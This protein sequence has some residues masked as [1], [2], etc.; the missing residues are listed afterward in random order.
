MNSTHSTE[1]TLVKML[2]SDRAAMVECCA[3]LLR[4]PSVNGVHPEITIAEAIADEARSLGLH[5][6]IVGADA[7]RPNVIVSTRAEGPTGLLLL[8]HLDTVP[9]GDESRWRF[10]P[11]AGV[12][13]DGRIYG[14]GAIDT[15]GGMTAALYALAA[16]ARIDGALPNGRAQ[17][18]CV[19]DEE[20]GATGTLGVKYLHDQGLLGGLG[21]I[22]A[23]SGA[24]IT[25]GHR[26]VLRY[27]LTCIG[28]A[29]H[30]GAHEWQEGTAGASAVTGMARLLVALDA[31]QI[32]FS[33][34]K[35]FERFRT[36]ITAGTVIS[37]GTAINIV[38][39]HCEA[40][41]DIRTTPEYDHAAIERLIQSAIDNASAD[42]RL[43]LTFTKL[44]EIPAVISDET[45]PI[46]TI[47][48][49]VIPQI[50][51]HSAERVVAGPANE[52]YLL[53]ERGIPTVCGLG[54]TGANAHAAD[55]YVEIDGLVQAAQIFA[56]TGA[57]LAAYTS[58]QVG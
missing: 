1:E 12:I 51:G 6:Q 35:Y 8:G 20:S 29:I 31:I 19:P 36:V 41:L 50:T 52:G 10:P 39:D 24:Q 22:Y 21:A 25:L 9:A 26:G 15:K 33:S 7:Q 4:I 27:R 58:L 17:L 43:R 30:T 38:P 44:N 48:D 49:E 42:R 14:R 40:L 47:L 57:R 13:V 2:E 32:D 5:V 11:F 34:R 16:L 3:R 28:E 55:E 53:I 23:Y 56:L 18:I 45:A 54:P 46:F 37:G